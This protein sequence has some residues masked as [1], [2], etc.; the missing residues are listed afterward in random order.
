MGEKGVAQIM[1]K[2]FGGSK[3]GCQKLFGRKYGH[4]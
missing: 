2:K 4:E 1:V 3:N